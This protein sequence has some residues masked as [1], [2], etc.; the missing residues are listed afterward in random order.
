MLIKNLTALSGRTDP[1]TW[2]RLST[3]K[4]IEVQIK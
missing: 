1:G 4:R 2:F 3:E